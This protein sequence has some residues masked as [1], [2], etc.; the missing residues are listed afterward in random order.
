MKRS[1]LI[2]SAALAA[3]LA[4]PAAFAIGR[5]ADISVVDRDTGEVLTTHPHRG[6]FWVEGRPGA[7]YAIRIRN[8]QGQRVLAVTSVDGVNVVTGET[9]AVD[10]RGYVFEPWSSY[11]IA[12]WR[13]SDAR[14]AAFEFTAV[15][16]SYAAKTGR[17]DNV[18]VIGIALFREKQQPAILPGRIDAP[19]PLPPPPP[20]P[21]D[22]ASGAS[23]AWRAEAQAG[24]NEPQSKSAAPALGTGH[25][26][27]EE[28]TVTQVGFDRART[29]PDEVIRVRYDSRANLVALGVIRDARPPRRPD[30]FPGTA[31]GYVPDP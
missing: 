5:V 30:A 3:T 15:P 7:R 14:I 13:K 9:A 22:S 2:V 1:L 26:R 24:A 28:S 16:K 27:S 18:G 11:D 23:R 6:E 8:G 4:H 29:Q 25:G 21:Q 10:Q 20:V 12:G 17:P 19:A 31:P